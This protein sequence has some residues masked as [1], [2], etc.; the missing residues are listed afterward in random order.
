M[1]VDERHVHDEIASRLATVGQRYTSGRRQLVGVLVRTGRPVT[2]PEVLRAEPS[3]SQ[4][5]AYRN[6]AVLE[7]AAVVRR[8]VQAGDHAYYELAEPLAEHHH[9]LVCD[10]CG[11]ITDVTLSAQLEAELDKAFRRLVAQHGFTA[12][13]HA[14][15]VYGA[16]RDCT[17]T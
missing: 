16:C 6:L 4:S 17:A 5:S 7:E 8:L 15:D 12:R 1:K 14:L 2:L 3:L 11:S 9:H 13:S 10:S